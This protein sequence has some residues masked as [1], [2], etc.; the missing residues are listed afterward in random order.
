MNAHSY[1]RVTINPRA[2][3]KNYMI[4]REK[5]GDSTKILAMIKAD[6]Y[7]HGMI[8]AARALEAVGCRTFGVAEIGEALQLRKAGIQGELFVMMGVPDD[9]MELI[10][11]HDL[12]PVVFSIEMLERLSLAAVKA[13]K[14]VGVHL[15]VDSGMSRLGFFPDEVEGFLNHLDRL[16]GVFLAGILSHFPQS[17]NVASA[18]TKTC[19]DIF[20]RTC[21]LKAEEFHGLKHIA[22]SGGIFNFPETC[23][24]MVRPGISLYGYYP[25]G[26]QGRGRAQGEK[27]V[28]AMTFTSRVIQVKT[29]AK[30]AGISYGHT[31]I[32]QQKM[33]LAVIPVGYEDGYM[34]SL[35]NKAQVLIGGRRVPIRGRICMNMCMADI[36]EIEGIRPGEEVVLLGTQGDNTISADE[37]AG[38][39]GTISYEVLCLIGNNNERVYKDEEI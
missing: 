26:E 25:D 14:D 39:A 38:W 36:S 13:G 5:V 12:T 2:L 35:S 22:N 1:N 6:A 9:N 20:A 11:D 28:P 4:I 10:V 16:P 17:D 8:K 32:A 24:D 30:G 34:R 29:V 31:Y 19:Y 21:E 7:G 33:R 37:I 27:L 3:Q 23:C 15:K 18:N